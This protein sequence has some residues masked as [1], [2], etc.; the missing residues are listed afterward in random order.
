MCF[1][2]VLKNT[3]LQI[4]MH[5]YAAINYSLWISLVS[6]YR[7]TSFPTV[8]VIWLNPKNAFNKSM[9]HHILH[10]AARAWRTRLVLAP[11]I[12]YDRMQSVPY[13]RSAGP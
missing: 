10:L 4:P 9:A 13:S 2:T 6:L 12:G 1:S 11:V 5:F 8:Q 3:R 7:Q